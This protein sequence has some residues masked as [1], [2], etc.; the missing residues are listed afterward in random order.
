MKIIALQRSPEFFGAPF[1]VSIHIGL[2]LYV[3]T[4][5]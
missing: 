1:I 3:R 5:I 4:D 2:R